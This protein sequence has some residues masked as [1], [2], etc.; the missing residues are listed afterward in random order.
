VV[1]IP[2]D[3]RTKYSALISEVLTSETVAVTT[4]VRLVGKLGFVGEVARRQSKCMLMRLGHFVSEQKRHDAQRVPL[5]CDVRDDLRW[6]W[7]FLAKRCGGSSLIGSWSR[8]NSEIIFIQSDTSPFGYAFMCND[9]YIFS[10]WTRHDVWA[11]YRDL[12]EAAQIDP[13]SYRDQCNQ[14]ALQMEE[15]RVTR[16][17]AVHTPLANDDPEHQ[18][19]GA[20]RLDA[21]STGWKE[22]WAVV[23]GL[24]VF[25]SRIRGNR[26][27]LQVDN[28]AAEHVINEWSSRSLVLRRMTQ[29]L[30]ETCTH[31]SLDIQGSHIESKCNLVDSLSRCDVHA[32]V[33]QEWPGGMKRPRASSATWSD[34]YGTM[35]RVSSSSRS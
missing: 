27:T 3:K 12:C 18:G 16:P 21:V 29:L 5:P 34:L 2:S 26:V 32:F 9:E 1:S 6:W 24:H 7:E 19:A 31:H 4:L 17:D 33:T 8:A 30:V 14:H 25:G 28:M 35:T 10:A 20:F 11:A 15:Q 23:V 13:T 22:L